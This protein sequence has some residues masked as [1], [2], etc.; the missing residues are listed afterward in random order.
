VI[1]WLCL[2]P[3]NFLQSNQVAWGSDGGL[4]FTPPATAYT[5]APPA[6]LASL[7]EWTIL[8]DVKTLAPL[9]QG[10]ILSYSLDERRCNLSVDQ[11]F[12]DIVLR[13]RTS[14]EQRPRE[15]RVE[16]IFEQSSDRRF[17]LAVVYDGHDLSVHIDGEGKIR[18]RIGAIDS[19]AWNSTYP[20]LLGSHADGKLG[21]K[22][23]FYQLTVLDR[24]TTS[25]ALKNPH[26]LFQDTAA[27]LSY[28]FDGRNGTMVLDQSGKTP[29][30]LIWPSTFAP[31]RLT[32][33]QSPRDY[34][35][36]PR[37]LLV[38]DIFA[39][40]VLYLP[41][42]YLISG[43]VRK[44]F[45]TIFTAAMAV[46]GGA[47]ISFVIETLQV[48]LPTRYSSTMDLIMNSLGAG[49]GVLAQYRGWAEEAV[50]LMKVSFRE[51]T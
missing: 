13:I 27:V 47:L 32:F 2:W 50:A 42:G 51:S 34:W 23:I 5:S 8:M 46:F 4:K 18:Q 6:K 3:F 25:E 14:D 30:N 40:I 43:M 48:Y 22:G 38:K 21:W 49:I 26:V 41:L 9:R 16:K 29:A 1:V 12:D 10:R 44:R 35:L 19:A 17:V 24:A 36:D 37:R 28:I 15:I 11:L 45:L 7:R 33:L 31:Y 20:V 39:N